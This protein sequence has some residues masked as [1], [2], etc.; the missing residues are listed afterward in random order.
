MQYDDVITN[1]RWGTDSKLKIILAIS[2]RHIVRL[3]Q[4]L[5]Q[6]CRIT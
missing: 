6:I 5:D 4:Y 3:M 1:S 2:R